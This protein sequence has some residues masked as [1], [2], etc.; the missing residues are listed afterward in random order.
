MAKELGRDVDTYG[1]GECENAWF[2]LHN[3]KFEAEEARRAALS[4]EERRKE[5]IAAAASW[6][7]KRI[8]PQMNSTTYPAT[9]TTTLLLFSNWL[10]IRIMGQPVGSASA[11][12]ASVLA[13][14]GLPFLLEN[15]AE[16][17]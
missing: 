3:A 9:C 4:P 8:K 17:G 1:E 5:D 15:G 14:T 13:N 10:P 11:Q 7:R 6:F 12:I 2:K 16:V